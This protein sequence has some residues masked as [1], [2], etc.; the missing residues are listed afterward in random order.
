MPWLQLTEEKIRGHDPDKITNLFEKAR[1]KGR[2]ND[3]PAQDQQGGE[4]LQGSSPNEPAST[5]AKVAGILGWGK[6]A[7]KMKWSF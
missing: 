2:P 7:A 4:T 5:S 6:Y 1:P 3:W